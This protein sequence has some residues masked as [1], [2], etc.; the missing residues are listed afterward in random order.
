M[1][2]RLEKTN[3]SLFRESYAVLVSALHDQ[4]Q[5]KLRVSGCHPTEGRQIIDS[6]AVC[7]DIYPC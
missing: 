1:Q 5:V 4:A 6:V 7:S 2:M 3:N